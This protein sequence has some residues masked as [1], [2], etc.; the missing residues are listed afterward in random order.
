MTPNLS[1]GEPQRKGRKNAYAELGRQLLN[2][3]FKKEV[4]YIL[5]SYQEQSR[6]VSYDRITELSNRLRLLGKG[7]DRSVLDIISDHPEE[8]VKD[9]KHV[10]EEG[11]RREL[12]LLNARYNAFYIGIVGSFAE[13][14][15][16]WN[17]EPF[18]DPQLNE[19]VLRLSADRRDG[20]R[21]VWMD[22]A[23]S[24]LQIAG[25]LLEEIIDQRG[26]MKKDQ[27]GRVEKQVARIRKLSKNAS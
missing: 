6:E 7:V 13:E 16:S 5:D 2:D 12:R 24:M 1:D 23:E 21:A 9:L 8:F 3:E 4:Y 22:D 26:S 20:A 14:W 18:F 15:R 19:V 10:T 17:I 25:D 27:L 11:A